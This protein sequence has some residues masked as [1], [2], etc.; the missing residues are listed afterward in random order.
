MNAYVSGEYQGSETILYN[1]A[2]VNSQCHLSKLMEFT[3]PT[4]NLNVNYR[5]GYKNMS[6]EFHEL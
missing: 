2:E 6:R 5:I 1:T 3:T 4:M